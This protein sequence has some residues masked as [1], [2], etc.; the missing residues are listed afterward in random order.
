[1]D[2]LLEPVVHNR[3]WLVIRGDGRQTQCRVIVVRDV[4]GALAFET[5]MFFDADVFYQRLH[6][7]R[8]L[9]ERDADNALKDLLDAGWVKAQLPE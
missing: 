3:R 4:F 5:R 6:P 2:I 8:E 1:M 9:A 7:T